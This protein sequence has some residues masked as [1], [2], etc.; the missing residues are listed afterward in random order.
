MLVHKFT[1]H[2]IMNLQQNH[3]SVVKED[4][5][6]PVRKHNLITLNSW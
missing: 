6:K 2:E 3:V 5:F 1:K 4:E